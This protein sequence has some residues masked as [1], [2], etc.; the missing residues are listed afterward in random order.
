MPQ[1]NLADRGKTKLIPFIIIG[2]VLAFLLIY[3]LLA[4][5]MNATYENCLH[6]EDLKQARRA[7]EIK[8][9]D[10]LYKTLKVV[11]IPVTQEIIDLSRDNRDAAV[12]RFAEDRCEYRFNPI[13]E[14]HPPIPPDP[15]LREF[16]L[17]LPED[18]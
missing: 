14:D 11:D 12:E 15:P 3:I 8:D 16:P 5:D 18:K 9:F 4:A 1:D 2:I 7:E 17:P 6:I 10:D 13:P